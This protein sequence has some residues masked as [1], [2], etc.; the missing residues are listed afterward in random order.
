MRCLTLADFLVKKM[1]D[2]Y[3]V[4]RELPG[5][6]CDY[7]VERGHKIFRLPVNGEEKF[8]VRDHQHVNIGRIDCF[9]DAE[10]MKDICSAY[11][12]FDWLIVDHYELGI[13]WELEVKNCVKR[14]MVIDDLASRAHHC[15]LL[16]DQNF[17]GE[18]TDPYSELVPI[19]CTKLIGTA[20]V[21]LR[22]EFVVSKDKIRRRNGKVERILIFFGAS[23]LRNETLKALQAVCMLNDPSLLID[24]VLGGNH[25]FK[26][27]IRDFVS[28][29]PQISCHDYV[30]RMSDLML[31]AD[32]YVGS[33]GT[34]TWER[35][36]VGLPGL[37]IAVAE[38]QIQPCKYL[39]RAGIIKYIGCSSDI[40]SESIS[41]SLRDIIS[42]PKVLDEMS[43][44][45]MALI[46]GLGT[47]RC[48]SALFQY[49]DVK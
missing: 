15:D 11:P 49:G 5:H 40:S 44:R 7:I 6:M 32:L 22:P 4:S 38:N 42:M 25:P 3:F 33:A 24:V 14:L 16:L 41:E 37:V 12:I 8:H 43:W 31:K 28:R 19:S 1:A 29:H 46:D 36:C 21:L 2:V 18:K 10:E 30:E 9:A 45:S 27:S 39:D 35:C 47:S 13:S 34:T 20:F 26:Q 23:D 48:V 17:Y